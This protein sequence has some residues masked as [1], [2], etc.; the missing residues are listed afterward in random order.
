[1]AALA[2]F[3]TSTGFTTDL[4]CPTETFV[5]LGDADCSSCLETLQA[6]DISFDVAFTDCNELYAGVSLPRS[7]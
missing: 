4:A 6:G 2:A 1:M 3:Q 7:R 5:C